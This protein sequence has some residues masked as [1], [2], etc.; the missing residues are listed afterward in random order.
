MVK[1]KEMIDNI[2]ESRRKFNEL[3]QIYEG[4]IAKLEEKISRVRQ[5]QGGQSAKS[6]K[7]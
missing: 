4:R 5:Q 1:V 3:I 6:N 2:R 7:E